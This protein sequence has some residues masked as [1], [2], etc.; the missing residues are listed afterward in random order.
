LPSHGPSWH[1][2]AV[3]T[4]TGKPA[5][6]RI[7]RIADTIAALLAREGVDYL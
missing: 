7:E 2:L 4:P 6:G 5:M 3:R 1:E